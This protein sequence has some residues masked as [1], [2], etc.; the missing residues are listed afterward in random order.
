[1]SY[2]VFDYNNLS[3][4]ISTYDVIRTNTPLD[5]FENKTLGF[6]FWC[7]NFSNLKNICGALVNVAKSGSV[8]FKVTR[9][10]DIGEY[11]YDDTIG[12]FSVSPGINTI[13]FPYRISLGHKQQLFIETSSNQMIY[14]E[15]NNGIG[16]PF[17]E[18]YPTFEISYNLLYLS[19]KN[20]ENIK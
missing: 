5:K 17:N 11:I 3:E 9:L 7:N 14:Y 4:N 19:N 16:Y 10:S 2:W 8:S 18:V 13:I 15:D 12:P 20:F 1:M 6:S